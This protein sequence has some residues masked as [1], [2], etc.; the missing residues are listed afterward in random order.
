MIYVYIFKK[1]SKIPR[2]SY[3][4][5]VEGEG[6]RDKRQLIYAQKDTSLLVQLE[7]AIYSPGQTVRF[8][9]FAIDSLT[10]AVNPSDRC[11]VSIRDSNGN[12]IE[13]YEPK[14][15]KGK[16]ENKLT[17]GEKAPQG[18]WGVEVSCGI[19]VS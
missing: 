16:Y 3:F 11:A 4:L 19:E 7:K 17:L 2:G 10:N 6:F 9:V 12:L 15:V 8:R 13:G 18:I 14:F 1:T 5:N